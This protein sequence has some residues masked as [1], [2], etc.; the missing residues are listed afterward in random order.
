M[1]NTERSAF[2]SAVMLVSDISL[3]SAAFGFISLRNHKTMADIGILPWTACVFAAFFIFSLFLRRERSAKSAVY[4]LSGL[5]AVSAAVLFVFF[6]RPEE[7]VAAVLSA[8]FWGLP[9]CHIFT[10]WEK[11]A[12]QDSLMKRFEITVFILLFMLIVA[13]GS[14]NSYLF[15]VPSCVSLALCII[16]LIVRRT[17]GSE[18]GSG[19]AVQVVSILCAFAVLC[20]AAVCAFLFFASDGVGAS[21]ERIAGAVFSAVMLALSSVGRFLRWLISL[22][23]QPESGEIPPPESMPSG[24]FEVNFGETQNM[25]QAFLVIGAAVIAA[26]VIAAVIAFAF[27]VRGR[28]MGGG[29]MLSRGKIRAQR[30]KRAP[31]LP[32]ILRSARFFIDSIIYRNTPQGVFVFLEGWGKAHRLA[33]GPGETPRHYLSRLSDARPEARPL[34]SDL[35][36]TLDARFYGGKKDGS[37]AKSELKSILRA[38]S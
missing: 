20:A 26:A 7:F 25:N 21:V 24:D 29:K 1:K 34:L 4:L 5:Y 33:R 9:F 37:F 13:A 16:A 27:F 19:G 18:S 22:L 6:R 10:L 30:K 36:D 38:F 28:K 17:A 31:L 3:L 2:C 11:P 32:K 8:I 14:E 35:S 23:P 12:T 15:A